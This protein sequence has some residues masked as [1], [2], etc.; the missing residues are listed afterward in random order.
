M[1]EASTRP[2]YD[3]F[4]WAYD[5]LISEPVEPWIDAASQILA[6][7]APA[8]ASVLDAGC[9]TGRHAA[10]LAALGHAVTLVDYSPELLARGRERLPFARSELA[11]LRHLQLGERFDL[12]T[13]RGVANDFLTDE[14]RERLLQRLAEHLSPSGVLMLDV[15]DAKASAQRYRTPRF[16]RRV[17]PTTDGELEFT[18]IGRM[19]HELLRFHERHVLHSRAGTI[20]REHDVDMRPWSR[21]ELKSRLLDAGLSSIE[22]REGVGRRTDD[23][24]L[25]VAHG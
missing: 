2:F 6:T 22:I 15:R 11:D 18:S 13:S 10:A 19:E 23:R 25:C 17:I 7:C 8:R 12:V 20:V 16:R 1:T 5:L 4:G 9:G 14:D 24:L 3:D 21:T